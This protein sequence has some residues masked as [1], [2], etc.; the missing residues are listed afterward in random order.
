MNDDRAASWTRIRAL[1]ALGAAVLLLAWSGLAHAADISISGEVEAYVEM[2]ST[3]FNGDYNTNERGRGEWG[4]YYGDG[5]ADE[6]SYTETRVKEAELKFK[7]SHALSDSWKIT[8]EIEIEF[9]PI[10]SGRRAN[11]YDLEEMSA[12]FSHTSGL[13]IAVGILEDKKL[14]EGGLVMESSS[15]DAKGFDENP[16]IRVGFETDQL[17]VDLR[18]S[19][20]FV[21]EEYEDSTGGTNDK[22][23]NQQHIRLQAEYVMKDFIE[24]M[25]TYTSVTS[26]NKQEADFQGAEA[27]L[28]A[29]DFDAYEAAGLNTYNVIGVGAVLT[30]G[31]I[32]PTLTHE[33]WAVEE[34]DGATEYDTAITTAGIRL[35]GLVGPGNL[36]FEVESGTSDISGDDVAFTAIAGEY[37]LRDGKSRYGPGFKTFSNDA[38]NEELTGTIFYVGGEWIF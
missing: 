10:N 22:I 36:V 38:P 8:N 32:Q 24:A 18:Y 13:F 15:E 7:G 23:V 17:E 11:D 5:L 37:L 34:D 21:E 25:L 20:I 14:Y 33:M 4:S 31:K 2:G 27:S 29:A 30:F 16:G 26:E 19:S 3:N 12:T 35:N 6:Y 9:K 1:T 28:G